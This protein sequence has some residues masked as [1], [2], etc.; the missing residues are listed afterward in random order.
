VLAQTYQNW[1]CIVVNDGST[2][3]TQAIMEEYIKKDKRFK[4]I[5]QPNQGQSATRN[6][7][8][9]LATGNYIQFLDA[10]D[11]LERRQVRRAGKVFK[12]YPAVDV[13]YGDVRYLLVQLTRKTCF[14]PGG[15]KMNLDASDFR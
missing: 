2:D 6:K 10:D 13:V 12:Q 11:L 9:S 15:V 3:N 14:S 1:E 7:G 4:H 5:Y 8:L